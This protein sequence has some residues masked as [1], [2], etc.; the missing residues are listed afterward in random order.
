MKILLLTD[1]HGNNENL[2]A[3]LNKEKFDA[4]LIAGDI[5]D[6]REFEDYSGKLNEILNTL[7]DKGELVKAIPGNMDPEEQCVRALIDRRM[8]LHKNIS[9]IGNIEVV[10]F[11][12]GITPFDTP[13]EPSEEE[14]KNSLELLHSR[15]TSNIKIGVIHHPPKDTAVDIAEEEHVGSQ[16]V[17]SLI[18]EQEFDL[19]LTGHIHKSRGID[20]VGDTVI[21]NPGPVLDG[22]YA[23]LDVENGLEIEMERL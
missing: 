13:F 21:V 16:K 18:Q 17:R 14:I 1:I 5:S 3:I 23:V 15:M 6:A 8:N 7:E 4:V 10:G 9:N 19:V 22:F 20:K 11:G 2:E 12:G